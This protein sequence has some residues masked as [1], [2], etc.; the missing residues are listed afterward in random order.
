M[1]AA[2]ALECG[3]LLPLFSPEACFRQRIEQARDAIG[4]HVGRRYEGVDVCCV[5]RNWLVGCSEIGGNV[6]VL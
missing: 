6:Q 1:S 4:D 2:Q 5:R 3:S